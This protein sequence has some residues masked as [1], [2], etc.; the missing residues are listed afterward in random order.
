MNPNSSKDM[1][2]LAKAIKT[3]RRSLR[4]FRRKR[5]KM[6][7][8]YVGSHYGGGGP[9][10]ENVMNLMYQTADTYVQALS[11]NRPRILIST[12]HNDLSW[13]AHHFQVGINNLIAEIKLEEIL[14]RAVLEAFFCIGIVKVYNA[15]AGLV[16]L[17][18]EDE[19]VDPGKPYADLVS[20]DDWFYDIRATSWRKS[21]FCGNRYRMPY[22]KFMRAASLDK[23]IKKEIQPPSRH[24]YDVNLEGDNPVKD[25]LEDES[26]KDDFEEMVTL[27][28]IWIPEEK[29]IITMAEDH[30]KKPLRVLDWDGP[31]SGPYHI[32]SFSDVPDHV[33]P[34][35]P[36]MTLKPLSDMINGL[37]RK[38]RRQA[39][40][41]KDI[42]F[43]QSGSHDDA[44][45][46]QRSEDGQW[47]RVDNPDSV[48]VLKMGG[49]DQGNLAFRMSMQE[50]YDRMAGNL[51]AM[52]GL[53]PQ[54]DTLGQDRL[55]HSQVS[56]RQANMQYKVVQFTEEICRDL[57][58]LL[59][60]DEILEIPGVTE[61]AGIELDSTWIPE[62]R[63]GDWFDY[64]F[65]VEPYS[66]QYK[67]PSERA[68]ALTQ[69]ISQI[70]MPMFPM[71]Q[72]Y[73]GNID[74][75][76]LIEIYSDLMDMPRLKQII[77]FEE[78]KKD[79]PGPNP[80]KPPGPPKQQGPDQRTTTSVPTGGTP[81]NKSHVMQ[82]LLQGGQPNQD[83]MANLG[84]M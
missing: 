2:R 31:E 10:R 67:S 69:F 34:L 3:S 79:R 37:L 28:D 59:W 52:A 1:S 35:S 40:R 24:T 27:R 12:K 78:P 29:Q 57:G 55:I 17:E 16:H 4:P 66:M 65:R 75:Q 41:Q 56:K 32:L 68:A 62:V 38:Q 77:M 23:K 46:L 53:G 30:S 14:R 84:R 42:P 43:Y 25:M 36:A 80:A 44:K 74:I 18:G 51:Q 50:V 26:D 72:E 15:D 13:F 7:A 64:N 9:D 82:Q 20:L 73:G 83:Q 6:V 60:T 49:V 19:W 39:Q 48:N 63:E 70:A 21:K 22:E 33:M 45:R 5:A 47:T 8:D 54:S 71:M 61:V 76:E 58:W 11:A 81:E